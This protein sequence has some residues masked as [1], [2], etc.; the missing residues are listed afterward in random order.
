M[1][2]IRGLGAVVGILLFWTAGSW[3]AALAADGVKNVPAAPSFAAYCK[4]TFA[5]SGRCPADVCRS[6]CPAET[7]ASCAKEACVPRDCRTIKA[8]DCPKAYCAVMTNCSGQKVCEDQMVGPPPKCGGLAY[9]GQD[10]SCCPG[11]VRRCGVEF[12]DG[13]CDMEGKNSVYD[14]PICIP[15][16]DG[17]CGQFEN[18]CNCPEDCT[19]KPPSPAKL[20][21]IFL[22]RFNALHNA[23]KR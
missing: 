3:T 22:D 15:C 5:A 19:T 11:F 6:T 7:S 4:K 14:L 12:Y 18:K 21:Q 10:V 20:R 2:K 23:G 8:K 1:I 13:T 16:G 17:V 9:E